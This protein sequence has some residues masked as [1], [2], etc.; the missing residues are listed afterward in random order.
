M[1]IEKIYIVLTLSGLFFISIGSLGLLRLP[2][3]FCRGHAL[4]KALT[5]GV[6]LL[7]LGACLYFDSR[8]ASFKLFAALLF[9]YATIPLSGHILGFVAFRKN[10][11]RWKHRQVDQPS[12]I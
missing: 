9:Q 3:V 8:N 12:K 4:T 10:V 6:T 11:K 7:L 2:D 1:M 5:L